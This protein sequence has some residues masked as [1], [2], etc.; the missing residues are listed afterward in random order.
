M[1]LDYQNKARSMQLN[2]DRYHKCS[3]FNFRF[4]VRDDGGELIAEGCALSTACRFQQEKL[5]TAIAK[6]FVQGK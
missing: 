2:G 1:W 3:M 6:C 5:R 4:Y